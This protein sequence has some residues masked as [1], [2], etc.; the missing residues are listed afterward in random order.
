MK[1]RLIEP[2]YIDVLH[3]PLL[4]DGIGQSECFRRKEVDHILSNTANREESGIEELQCHIVANQ[5]GETVE[6]GQFRMLQQS[7]ILPPFEKH[8]DSN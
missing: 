2:R 6:F 3:R 8:P 5:I 7:L 1:C 4:L